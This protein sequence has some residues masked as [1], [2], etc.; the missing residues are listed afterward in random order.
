MYISI[1]RFSSK[2]FEA[3]LQQLQS[4]L[5]E[6]DV[7]SLARMF[8]GNLSHS[9][10]QKLSR[11]ISLDGSV[12]SGLWLVLKTCLCSLGCVLRAIVL[13][14]D[15]GQS[16]HQSREFCGVQCSVVC[17]GLNREEIKQPLHKLVAQ[18]RS[19]ICI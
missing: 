9:S 1:H 10:V 19:A 18:H 13:L 2:V 15:K 14:E 8:L 7:T 12:Q 6:Y 5:F 11:S 4:H 16:V 17:S 3:L